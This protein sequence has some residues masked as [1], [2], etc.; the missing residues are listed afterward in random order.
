MTMVLPKHE[1]WTESAYLAYEDASEFRHEFANGEIV[2]MTGASLKHNMIC[3]NTSTALNIQLANKD[4]GV[5]SN[6]M[7]L[8]IVSKRHYRYPDVMVFCGE[9]EFFDERVDTI[10]NPTVII[11][12]L[13]ESTEIIDRNQKLD[14]Y[15]QIEPLQEYILISQKEAKIERYLRRESGDWLYT[16]VTDLDGQLKLPSIDCQLMLTDVYNKVTFDGDTVIL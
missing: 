14:E 9:P 10:T 4:C 12:V 5:V 7:R 1:I 6:D 13:S 11:E 3:V 8:Q 16:K 2:A 15:L